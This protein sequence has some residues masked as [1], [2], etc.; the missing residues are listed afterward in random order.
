[1]ASPVNT[2]NV[3][4]KSSHGGT[5]RAFLMAYIG[6]SVVPAAG[7][8]LSDARGMRASGSSVLARACLSKE[9]LQRKRNPTSVWLDRQFAHSKRARAHV[10]D[11][12]LSLL[13]VLAPPRFGES[14]LDSD[15]A[16]TQCVAMLFWL[17]IGL[18]GKA[19]KNSHSICGG[20]G[21]VMFATQL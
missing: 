2:T 17:V 15:S 20:C 19:H 11:V 3:N 14:Y 6:P 7:A 9:V 1:M 10:E 5:S 4:Q 13:T 21:L 8:I 18:F 16:D 12:A